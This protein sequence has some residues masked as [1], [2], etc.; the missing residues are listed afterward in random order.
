MDHRGFQDW[1]DRY[2]GA[3]RSGVPAE[4]L[5]LFS[6]DARYSYGPFRDWVVGREAIAAG[7]LRRPD[8]PGSWEAEYRPLA[9]DGE[10]A[11][12]VGE[13]RYADGRRYS[14]VFACR[15]DAEGRC[16]EFREWFMKEPK[17]RS[18]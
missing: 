5:E 6:D 11:V 13:T 15:F 7:W 9:V 2:V 14:N 10:V 17:R 16:V 4:I 1:L 18:A 3:W 12:A 8:A